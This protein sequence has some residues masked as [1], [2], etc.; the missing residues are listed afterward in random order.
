MWLLA[1]VAVVRPWS[2]AA[3]A[4][5]MTPLTVPALVLVRVNGALGVPYTVTRGVQQSL[6]GTGHTGRTQ[7]VRAS[8]TRLITISTFIGGPVVVRMVGALPQTLS[9]VSH[10]VWVFTNDTVVRVRSITRG[11]LFITLHTLLLHLVL[12]VPH[13]T[14]LHTPELVQEVELGTFLAQFVLG[15]L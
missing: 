7:V 10:S 9:L 8:Q 2:E 5:L 12:K 6:L 13:G 4:G 11:A 14:L 15:T 3:E 1:A